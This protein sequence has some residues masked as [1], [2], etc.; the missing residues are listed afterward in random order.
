MAGISYYIF[1]LVFGVLYADAIFRERSIY[2]KMW[3]G[4]VIGNIV[5]MSGIIP[6]AL[7]LGFN[8]LSHI[9]LAVFFVAGYFLLC[10]KP[11]LKFCK[12]NKYAMFTVL[13]IWILICALFCNH[14]MVKIPGGIASGQSTYSDLA[15]HMG[16]ITSIAEHG[17]F[18]PEYN[19]LAGVKLSYPFLADSL[20]SS[21]YIFGT[22]LKAAIL[23]PSFVMSGLVVC[24]FFALAKKMTGKNVTSVLAAVMFFFGGGFGF[25]YFLDKAKSNPNN[26]TRIF[27]DYYHT[28]TNFNEVNIRWSNA[29]C[30]MII[31]Q[32]TTMAGWC[33]LLFALWLLIDA[34]RSDKAQKY[35]LL[36]I[37][38]G[39]M[40]MIHTHSFFA[41][42]IISATA[43]FAFLP[44]EKNKKAYIRNWIIYGASAMILALPQLSYWTFS[45]TI[46]NRNFL[47]LTFNWVNSDDPYLW[48]WLKNWG[49][50]FVFIMPAVLCAKSENKKLF[51]GAA[52]IFMIAELVLF[53]PNPYD[54][55]KLFFVSYMLSVILVADYLCMI[56]NRLKAI[57]GT[58]F[59]SAVIVFFSIFSGVLTVGREYASGGEYKTFS[60]AE[61]KFAEF[62]KRN[63]HT[64]VFLTGNEHLNPISV[65]AGRR[66]YAGSELYVYFHGL[67]DELYRRY[68][69]V[70]SI[71]TA[72]TAEEMRKLAEKT[73]AGIEYL[74]LS[75]TEKEKFGV[76]DEDFSGLERIYCN[77]GLSLY[78]LTE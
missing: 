32:R 42:G 67:G 3:S 2:F 76:S 58:K 24:G 20:S 74:Y 77:D 21:L 57:R 1:F 4:G 12:P 38:A 43:F 75:D 64:T 59:L 56:Y 37:I 25:S 70:Q 48:F 73:G 46:G 14:I 36:G 13:P 62:V 50:V 30:D 33:V 29:I 45:Q 39:L 22:D 54:N 51:C 19:Q 8:K 7:L 10:K 23:L 65:L 28:P 71:Y 68:D 78:K 34:L 5:L 72:Q 41:L 6:L 35:L 63:T 60:D 11:C 26:F 44:G 31:P 66:V 18:P 40:P 69:E 55:N 17:V 52:L 9:L 47:K 15:M 16:F 27:T 53:Q 61:I 49:L